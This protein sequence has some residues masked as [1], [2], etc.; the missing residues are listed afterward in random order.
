[1]CAGI[2]VNFSNVTVEWADLPRPVQSGDIVV[3]K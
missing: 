2:P 1:M 3:A